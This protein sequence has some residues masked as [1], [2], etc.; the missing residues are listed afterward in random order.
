[1]VVENVDII[2]TYRRFTS[3]L[4]MKSMYD[5]LSDQLLTGLKFTSISPRFSLVVTIFL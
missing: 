2:E 5:L 3:D 4:E 1:M